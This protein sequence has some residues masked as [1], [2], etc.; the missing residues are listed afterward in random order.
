MSCEQGIDDQYQLSGQARIT[1]QVCPKHQLTGYYDKLS[2]NRGHA[3]A[4]GYD[5]DNGVECLGTAEIRGEAGQMDLDALGQDAVR[6]GFL[7][8]R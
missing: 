2:K 7:D 5:P 3:M 6:G 8:R 4:A 1:W